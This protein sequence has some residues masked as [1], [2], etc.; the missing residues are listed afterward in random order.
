MPVV[1][2]QCTPDYFINI[3]N[4]MNPAHTGHEHSDKWP[5]CSNI[6]NQ[7]TS[8]ADIYRL[9]DYNLNN[10]SIE[11]LHKIALYVF[12]SWYINP[13]MPNA[14]YYPYQL[15]SSIP[16]LRVVGWYFLHVFNF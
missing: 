7:S 11:T 15:D 6:A 1:Y 4:S 8:A 13:F 2:A 16:N 5:Q 3:A 10:R 12:S 14:F 9:Y